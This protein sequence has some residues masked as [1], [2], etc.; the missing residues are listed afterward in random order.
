MRAPRLSRFPWRA[1]LGVCACGLLLAAA[2]AGQTQGPASASELEGTS[3]QLVKIEGSDAKIRV[4]SERGH[5][6]LAFAPRGELSARIDCNR[7]SGTWSSPESGRLVLGELA[8]TRAQCAP[9]SLYDEIIAHWT[10][11]RSYALRDGHLMLT[12]G[13]GVYEYE[14]LPVPGTGPAAAP[15]ATPSH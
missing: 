5:Y 7:G 2:A 1:R 12:G 15:A 10:E 13:G 8:T 3:W 11:V 14:P 6:L 9:G 4:P